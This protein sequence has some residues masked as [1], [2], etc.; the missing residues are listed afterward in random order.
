MGLFKL[1]KKLSGV[2]NANP[3]IL[4]LLAE[5]FIPGAEFIL[6]ETTLFSLFAPYSH[7]YDVSENVLDF[8]ISIFSAYPSKHF[9]GIS[10]KNLDTGLQLV[11]PNIVL[12]LLHVKYKNC[13]ALVSPT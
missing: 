9:S 12:C 4:L 13:S 5:I 6:Y 10:F 3:A 11:E 1:F 7:L 2:L 8:F